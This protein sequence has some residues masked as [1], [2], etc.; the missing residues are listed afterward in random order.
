MSN[1]TTEFIET[2]ISCK[3]NGSTQT[4]GSN[5]L[6]CFSATVLLKLP[7]SVSAKPEQ[8]LAQASPKPTGNL[9][10]QRPPIPKRS[11]HRGRDLNTTATNTRH[12]TPP[13]HPRPQNQIPRGIPRSDQI[14]APPPPCSPSDSGNSFSSARSIMSA[15]LPSLLSVALP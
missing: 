4:N 8:R 14:H 7:G 9:H 2:H 15:R 1:R 6:T 5:E 12:R 11:N 13:T 3:Q 10:S